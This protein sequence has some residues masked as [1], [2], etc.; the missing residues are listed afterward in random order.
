MD[1]VPNTFM[2]LFWGYFA[3]WCLLTLYLLSLGARLRKA[4]KKLE[5]KGSQQ[6]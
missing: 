2:G 4:I 5:E 1:I 6:N 3:F